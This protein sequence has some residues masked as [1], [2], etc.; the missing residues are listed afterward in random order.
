MPITNTLNF[1]VSGSTAT[2][3]SATE[4]TNSLS[5]TAS[6]PIT[7]NANRKG[8]TIFNTLSVDVFVDIADTVA[9]NNYMFKLPAGSFY[10]MPE[11]IYTGA[12]WLICAS[13]TGSVEIREFS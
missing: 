2:A 4:K 10:E 5:T 1:A 13:G 12:L 7:V 9:A 11:P 6:N 8:L 3:S